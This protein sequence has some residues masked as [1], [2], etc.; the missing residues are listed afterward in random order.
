MNV[1]PNELRRQTVQVLN[2]IDKQI[3]VIETEAAVRNVSPATLRDERGNYVISPLLLA[4]A[5]CL[6]TLALINDKR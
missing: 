6:N 1:S 3:K 2:Q 4:K 5:Q